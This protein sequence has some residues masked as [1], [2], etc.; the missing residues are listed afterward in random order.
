MRIYYDDARM[1]KLYVAHDHLNKSFTAQGKTFYQHTGA[2]GYSGGNDPVIT[3][4]PSE[5]GPFKSTD[6]F[7][8][9]Y[10]SDNLF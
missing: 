7:K 1:D 3:T 8:T 2:V 10:T 4:Y 6:V 9:R 5:V